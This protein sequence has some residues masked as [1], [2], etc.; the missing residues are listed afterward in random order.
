[1]FKVGEGGDPVVAVERPG[2]Q[3]REAA[4][5]A[6]DPCPNGAIWLGED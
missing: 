5:E 6:V 3:L 1:L 2:D 4:E